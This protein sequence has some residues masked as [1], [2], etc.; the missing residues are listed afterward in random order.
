[1][2]RGG[3][4][5]Q[6]E[7][8]YFHRLSVPRRWGLSSPWVDDLEDARRARQQGWDDPWAE[9]AAGHQADA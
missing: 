2:S 8:K 3:K 5:G 7:E 9:G 4:S 1:M 6:D